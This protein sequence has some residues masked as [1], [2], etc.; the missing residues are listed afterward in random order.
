MKLA[1]HDGLAETR[2]RTLIGIALRRQK[3]GT[4]SLI[5]PKGAPVLVHWPDLTHALVGIPWAV[6]GAV[7]T[8]SYMPEH[9]TRDLDVLIR[10]EDRQRVT[11]Q[12]AD[13]GF[14]GTGRLAIGGSTWR[15]P[16]GT[17]VDVIEGEDEW[18]AAALAEAQANL[19]PQG[20]PTLPLPYLVLMKLAASRVQDVADVSRMMARADDVQLSRTRALIQKY[21]PDAVEDLESLIFLGKME[22][23]AEPS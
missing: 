12:L 21:E 16:D 15:A 1:A 17:P 2:R 10:A 6:I 7:A 13:T 14:S 20:L 9:A 5:Q 18:V 8:R 22:M 19:D 4:G 11:E 3:P 23:G